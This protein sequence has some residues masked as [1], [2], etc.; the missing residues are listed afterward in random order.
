MGKIGLQLFSVW[1]D[2]EKDFLGTLQKVINLG[3]E[4]IQFAGF[5][6]TPADQVKKLLEENK[7]LVAGAHV[8][9]HQLLNDEWE[10]TLEYH[11]TL[12]NQL[13]I[14]PAL[15][16]EMRQTM[17]DYKRS[18]EL[19]NQIG[20]K[21][22]EA[23][24]IFGYHNHDFEFQTFG[25]KTGLELLFDNTDP[26]LV[27][28]ELDCYWASFA[29]H[30]ALGIIRKYKNRIVSLHIKDMKL[31]SG[32]KA[33]TEIGHGQLDFD[34]IVKVGNEF[35]IEWFTVEQEEFERDPYESLT[36]NV[37]NLKKLRSRRL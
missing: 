18:A 21:C 2:A 24:F 5:Y 13:I 7:T 9:V 20:Q 12:Q 31:E 22:H 4:G 8:G 26:E 30:D 36:I 17:D 6:D 25:E 15:P 11:H 29:D 34:S 16:K 32:Q 28:M 23:G 19:L 14:C 1:K 3:Y 10:K 33:G 37:E 27:K 35:G